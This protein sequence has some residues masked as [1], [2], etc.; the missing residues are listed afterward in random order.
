[1]VCP[2]PVCNTHPPKVCVC[3]VCSKFFVC[4]VCAMW[5]VCDVV[6]VVCVCGVRRGFKT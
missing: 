1:M 2:A 5:C 6:C 4:G 3:C